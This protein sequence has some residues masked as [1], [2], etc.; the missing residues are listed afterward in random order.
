MS[1]RYTPAQKRAIAISYAKKDAS[2]VKG[3]GTYKK[4]APVKRAV[5]RGK[6]D[7]K[8][9]YGQR[10]GSVVGEGLQELLTQLGGISGAKAVAGLGDYKVKQNSL[11]VSEGNDPPEIVN[12]KD[13]RFIVRHREY[14]QDVSGTSAF[15][16]SSWKINP[17]LQDSF[18]WLSTLAQSFEQYR[19]RGM[20]FE[21][22]SNFSEYAGVSNLGT[23]VMATEYDSTRPN[24]SSK[25][26]MENH[27]YASS[28]KPSCSMIH[29][30]ECARD[31]SVLGELYIRQGEFS[32]TQDPRMSD[33]GNFQLA[34][35]GTATGVLGELWVTYEVE[36]LK[37][38]LESAGNL[39]LT[40]YYENAT[41]VTTA[42]PFGTL[43]TMQMCSGNEIAMKFFD[44]GTPLVMFF[45]ESLGAGRYLVDITWGGTATAAVTAPSWS[46]STGCTVTSTMPWNTNNMNSPGNGETSTRYHS[47]VIV[48]LTGTVRASMTITSGVLPGGTVS[49]FIYVTA[50]DSSINR[51]DLVT[52]IQPAFMLD[53]KDVKLE[54]YKP[55]DYGYDPANPDKL[56]IEDEKQE[57]TEEEEEEEVKKAEEVFVDSSGKL[58]LS[59]EYSKSD[60]I[61]ILTDMVRK[62]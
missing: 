58:I 20:I 12:A 54:P 48:E 40:S 14:L 17:G 39:V 25:L 44:S 33:F 9:D 38:R 18:P 16:V 49:V 7:Y 56:R 51:A 6:G 42:T 53:P 32:S 59:G 60:L 2:Y 41:G 23:I 62:S 24:F 37:P 11:L 55:G 28:Q 29:P 30:I 46:A 4:V 13:G 61:K 26:Q 31:S 19:L 10:L 3:R 47:A 8:K 1:K 21:F 50:V 57:E 45:P 15:T 34:T 36:L 35:V 27:Q 22:K 5:Y 43:S 52:Y